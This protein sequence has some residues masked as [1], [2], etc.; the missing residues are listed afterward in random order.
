MLLQ[1]EGPAVEGAGHVEGGIAVFEAAIAERQDDLALRDK[2]PVEI[3]DAVVGPGVRPGI[4]AGVTHRKAPWNSGARVSAKSSTAARSLSASVSSSAM[5]NAI[6]PRLANKMPRATR[7]SEKS[8]V[9][10]LRPLAPAAAGRMA[11]SVMS[12][13]IMEP[14]PVNSIAMPRRR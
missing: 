8:S 7:S 2:A 14:I 5:D 13:P 9:S 12:T 6:M 1:L 3:R 4:G 10:R 11:R